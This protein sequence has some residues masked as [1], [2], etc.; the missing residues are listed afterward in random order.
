MV[1]GGLN[2]VTVLDQIQVDATKGFITLCKVDPNKLGCE[3]AL[4]VKKLY[5]GI[6]CGYIDRIS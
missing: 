6:K 5:E 3:V 2:K 4:K 1:S